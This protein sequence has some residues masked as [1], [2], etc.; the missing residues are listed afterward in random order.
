MKMSVEPANDPEELIQYLSDRVEEIERALHDDED[1]CNRD[2]DA[3]YQAALR[4]VQ[5]L[6]EKFREKL[7]E[8]KKKLDQV[9]DENLKTSKQNRKQFD[10]ETDVINQLFSSGKHQEGRREENVFCGERE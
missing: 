5:S 1:F 8:L 2:I 10:E 6:E 9:R 7:Q 3:T 4:Y